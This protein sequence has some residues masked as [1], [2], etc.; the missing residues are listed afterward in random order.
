MFY[1]FLIFIKSSKILFAYT[2][3]YAGDRGEAG[4]RKRFGKIWIS[5]ISSIV[6]KPFRKFFICE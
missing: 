4:K 6:I 1:L 3:V 5:V 2:I